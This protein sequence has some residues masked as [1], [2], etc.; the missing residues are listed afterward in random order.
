MVRDSEKEIASVLVRDGEPEKGAMASSSAPPSS[1]CRRRPSW[2]PAPRAGSVRTSCG[3]S[4]ANRRR[5]R[6]RC[7]VHEPG[8]ASLLE[9]IDP[10]IEVVVGDVRDPAVID[11]LF[12]GV[13]RASVLHAAAV[14]HPARYV[15]SCST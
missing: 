10:R 2:S 14:I 8:D 3:R 1:A 15:R 4:P 13:G 11:E 6:I 7:L 12:D 5:R 9:V